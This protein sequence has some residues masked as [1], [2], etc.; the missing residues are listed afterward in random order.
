MGGN[1]TLMGN[2]GALSDVDA[3]ARNPLGLIV[4]DEYGNEY[5]YA[6]GVA[7]MAAGDW[8]T[9]NSD[10]SVARA[11]STPLTGRVGVAMAA[12]VASKYGWYQITGLVSSGTLGNSTVSSNIA[13]DSAAD[14]KPLFLSSSAGRATTTL[15]AGCAIMGA[16][17]SGAAASNVGAAWITRPFAP[18]FTLASA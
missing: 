16:W 3:T 5:M 13:T 15:A 8:A 4:P 7:S 2:S 14:K 17:A 1:K 18:G 10:Y 11:L 6:G 12:L 9:I